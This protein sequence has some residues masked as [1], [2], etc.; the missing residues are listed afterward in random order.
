MPQPSEATNQPAPNAV[1]LQ[2]A[3]RAVGTRLEAETGEIVLEQGA[4]GAALYVVESGALDVVVEASD[5]LR[6][7]VVRL[8]PGAHF[9]E[10][11]LLTGTP[12]SADVV[13]C[14]PTVLWH[15]TAEQFAGLVREEPGLMEYV[16]GQLA[17]RLRHTNEQLA[18]QSQ[19]HAALG[20]LLTSQRDC[21][22][23]ADLPSMERRSGVEEAVAADGPVLIVGEEGVGK[24]ALAQ[25][26][27]AL[28]G[29]GESA[30][31]VVDCAG[32]A[33]EDARGQLFGDADP[34]CV[35]RFA[36]RLGFV[37]AADGG[38][39]VL[40][41]VDRLPLGTQDDLAAFLTSASSG[42]AQVSLRTVVTATLSPEELRRGGNLSPS[43][44]EALAGAQTIS[45]AP[46]RRRRRDI[47]PLAEHFLECLAQ[48]RGQPAKRLT[49]GAR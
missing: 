13:A 37:Q 9:G 12:V 7:P 1:R 19:Q 49:E 24:R 32:L 36:D 15:V 48:R 16:A 3:A 43:L 38:T 39:L 40:A 10:M 27:H 22:Y 35:T 20:R 29:R 41:N 21:P 17:S 33:A 42:P 8:G 23:R 26:L 5:D 28:S 47:V 46:L 18:A 31:L 11:S 14:E 2:Q 45:L 44:A 30:L 6:L 25:H 34:A 4:P